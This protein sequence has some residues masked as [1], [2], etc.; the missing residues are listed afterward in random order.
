MNKKRVRKAIEQWKCVGHFG[1]GQG[2]ALAEFGA[3]EIGKEP[4]CYEVCPK[5]SKCRGLHFIAMD[6]RFP[7]LGEIVRK[8]VTMAS[9]TGLPVVPTVVS[10]MNVAVKR[11]NMEALRIQEGLKKYRVDSMTD[12][13][14]YGQF[15]NIDNGIA[16]KDPETQPTLFLIG[17]KLS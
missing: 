5:S 9:Q 3:D 7:S 12:H 10:A 2:R 14:V 8:T 11:G 4:I 15:E 17:A 16:K 13:Y 6:K 1:Y